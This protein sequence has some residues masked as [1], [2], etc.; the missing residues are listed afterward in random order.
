[1]KPQPFELERYF[2]QHEFTTRYLLGSSDP[3]SMSVD[4]LLALE[5]GAH[6]ALLDLWLGYTESLGNPQLRAA[7]AQ[8]TGC[9][10]DDVLVHGG[11]QEPIF[12]FMNVVLSAGDHAIVQFP[13]YQSHYAIAEALG[14]G[15][16]RWESDPRAGWA[17]DPDALARAIT[18]K[19][20]AIVITTPNNPTGYVF[21]RERLDAT[22]EIARKHGL[23]LFSDEVY[24]GSE[25]DP[26]DVLPAICTLYERGVSLG[27]MAKVYGLAGLRIG[28]IATRDRALYDA[29]AAFKDYLTICNA[30]PSE[31][32][33]TV[34]LRHHDALIERVRAITTANLDRLDAYFAERTDRWE[35]SRPRGGTTA[36]PRYLAGGTQAYCADLAARAGV[37][38]V[39]SFAFDA[40]DDR[41]RI[42]YGRLN[43]PEALQALAAYEGTR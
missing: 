33:A 34:A 27:A 15:I 9:G 36:F 21:D 41:V 28:W 1:V 14:A 18:P 13:A 32:L 3:E 25:R 26:V 4:E 7:I 38:L 12:S 20:R 29:M 5:P 17:P 22:I 42:G 24:R 10:L 2:A 6:D 8:V 30:A 39:P 16:T 37:L 23:W 35:W 40:G 43:L 31:W 11:A 19:T